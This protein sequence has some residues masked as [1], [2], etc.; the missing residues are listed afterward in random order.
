MSAAFDRF[1]HHPI[2]RAGATAGLVGLWFWLEIGLRRRR[3]T[4]WIS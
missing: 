2:V 1:S 4:T 3:L